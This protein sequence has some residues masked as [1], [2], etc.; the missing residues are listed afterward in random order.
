MHRLLRDVQ[1]SIHNS[2]YVEPG[3]TTVAELLDRYL[4][5]YA[6][7]S[8]GE[9]HRHRVKGLIDKHI[10]PSLGSISLRRLLPADIQRLYARKLQQ[11]R[12]DGSGGLSAQT[13]LHM[14]H[15]L[16]KACDLAVRWQMM[17]RNPVGAVTAP[18]V[19]RKEIRVLSVEEIGRL[20]AAAKG[21]QFLVPIVLA[22]TTAMRRGEICGL[23]WS[24]IN[25][26]TGVLSLRR[27]LGQ[28]GKR[29]F[30]KEPKTAGSRRSILLP[31]LAI[32][33]LKRHRLEQAGTRQLLGEAYA[34][35]D[36]V[37]SHADGRPLMPDSISNNFRKI[38]KKAGIPHTRFHVL[39]HSC[40]TLLIGN[41]IPVK[42]VSEILGHSSVY[43]T[44]DVYAHVLPHMQEQAA[45]T[46]DRLLSRE[47]R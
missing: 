7:L 29:I 2:I 31:N 23:K 5:D 24:D 20:L 18:R 21:T 4:E 43:T 34:N 41:G 39:R 12:L 47:Q 32:D 36:W 16:H 25:P 15:I 37:C 22:A 6:S 44:Q 45:G 9:K 13:V 27:S 1:S 46:I 8:M 42:M 11:G 28:V 38:L 33:V 30:C 40:A 10:S 3:D 17:V 14:H 19:E 26:D 35:E